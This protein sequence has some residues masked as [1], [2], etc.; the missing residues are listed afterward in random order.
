M[1]SYCHTRSTTG[2]NLKQSSLT[3]CT[4]LGILFFKEGMVYI[5]LFFSINIKV[6]LVVSQIYAQEKQKNQIADGNEVELR[7]NAG[8]NA[9]FV[10]K[11][12]LFSEPCKKDLSRHIEQ[13]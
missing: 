6:I 13:W 11:I 4:K 12:L 8:F 3:I 5:N 2:K 1:N 9:C 10:I 7:L